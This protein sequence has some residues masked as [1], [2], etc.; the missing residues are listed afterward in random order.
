MQVYELNF[1]KNTLVCRQGDPSNDL[2]YLESGKLLVCT[3]SGT[4]VKALARIEPGK[5]IGELAFF[6]GKPRSSHIIALEKSKIIQIPKNDL[7]SLLPEWFQEVG[8]S[9]TKKIRLLDHVIQET[10][11]R[12]FSAED[13]KPLTIQEQREFYS[14]IT[15]Q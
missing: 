8:K 3:I 12:R 1:E 10:N 2:F 15:Q 9:L 6:D 5:F 14:L 13:Q 11:I 4:E 7:S